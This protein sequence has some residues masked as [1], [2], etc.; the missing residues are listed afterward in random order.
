MSNT[1]DF[2]IE[3]KVLTNYIGPGGDVVIPEGISSIGY[4][5]FSCCKSLKCI[6]I[7]E[8]V[9]RI[10]KEAFL[11]CSGLTSIKLPEGMTNIGDFAFSGCT[12]LTSIVIPESM[13]SIG[14]SVFLNCDNIQFIC[15][16]VILVRLFFQI[17][18][19]VLIKYKG[20]GGDVVMPED[21]TSIGNSAFMNCSSLTSI[22]FPRSVSRIGKEAFRNCSNLTGINI[23]ESVTSIGNKA[24]YGCSKLRQVSV[25]DILSREML[26]KACLCAAFDETSIAEL[27]A[28]AKSWDKDA[29]EA[30]FESCLVSDT[31][32]AMLLAEKR[33]ELNKYA[34]LRGMDVD[35]LRDQYLSDLGLDKSGCKSYNL[36]NVTA[37][38]RMNPDFTFT[39]ELPDGKKTGTLPKKGADPALLDKANKDFVQMKKDLRKICKNRADLLLG[40]FCSGKERRADYW[41]KTYG[42]NPILHTMAC[43]LVWEQGGISF[44]RTDAGLVTADLTTYAL[45]EEPIRLAHPM[46]MEPSA[47]AA[48]QRYFNVHGL[49]QPFAQIWERV[50]KPEEIA[51][52]R[53][54]GCPILFFQLQGAEK[55]GFDH[56]LKIPGCEIQVKWSSETAPN[57]NKVSYCDIQSFKIGTFSRAVNH[58]LAYLDRVT[59]TGRI[60]KDDTDVM[61]SMEGCSPADLMSYIAAAQEANANNVL[62]ALLEYKNT[63]FADFD[64]MAEFTLEW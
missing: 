42:S 63:H 11:G 24:F 14:D 32:T 38:V 9:K 10:E 23:P 47:L 30:F 37:T 13:I 52:D 1:S 59:I 8:G 61:R 53:Y 26:A 49:K 60:R 54:C 15:S 64:P 45:T 22:T 16:D 33:K 41:S 18:N 7:P 5:A 57:G 35:T 28:Q 43:L 27:I 4:S 36:G 44:L 31:R 51:S 50:Y 29:Q 39:V 20:L 19:N 40:D 56:E 12:S 58:A 46:E 2:I 25:P 17:K 6:E 3:R 48:W 55:H 34:S 21:V 62:A